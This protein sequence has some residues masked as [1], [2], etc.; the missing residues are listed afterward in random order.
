[1]PDWLKI[2]I[3][4]GEFLAFGLYFLL[5]GSLARQQDTDVARQRPSSTW[6]YI[7]FAL[8]ILFTL[9]FFSM[10]TAAWLSTIFGALYLFSLIL[11]IVL[12]IQMRQTIETVM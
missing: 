5:L 4:A 7:Q 2:L 9:L 10:R 6:A 3:D 1:M 8:F 12:T 11:A